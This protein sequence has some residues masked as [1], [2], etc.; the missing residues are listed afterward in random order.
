M[1]HHAIDERD[2]EWLGKVFSMDRHSF[3]VCALHAHMRLTE[4]LVKGIF[5]R[6]IESRRVKQLNEAFKTHLGL[7]HKWS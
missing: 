3:V 6:A 4:A 1:S 5:G 2:S 7:E